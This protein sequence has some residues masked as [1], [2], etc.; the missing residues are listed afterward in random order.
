[1]A[2]VVRR[3]FALVLSASIS[4]SPADETAPSAGTPTPGTPTVQDGYVQTIAPVTKGVW[5]IAQPQAFHIQPIGN[6]VVIEHADGLVLI[7]GGGSTG[8]GR[9]IV[10]LV[11]SVSDKPVKAIALTHWHGDHVLGVSAIVQ[12][13]P[14]A[15]VIATDVTDAHLRG[16]SMKAYPKGAPDA[17]LQAAFDQRLDSVER[18]LRDALAKPGLAPRERE[19][20]AASQRLFVQYRQDTRDLVLALPTRTF[21]DS[22]RLDDATHPVELRHPGRGN[23]DGDLIAWLPRQ[24]VMVAGDLLVAPVP[25]GF[26]A[27]PADWQRTLRAMQAQTPAWWIPGHGAAMRDDGYVTRVVDLIDATRDAVA[28]Q[29]RQGASMDDAKK[30]IDLSAGRAQFAG[31]DP[32]LSRW[33]DRYWT[34]PF[35]EAAYRE[36]TGAPIEQGEG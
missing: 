1:M 11:R 33:F 16:R 14:S 34:Q 3:L 21:V 27:Y 9:R 19:G 4:L 15:E 29:V 10:D 8:A 2:R 7:D 28:A 12:A 30:R 31:D 18:S 25:F 24:R 17:T 23:T 32:W 35:I 26:N 20:F 36:A 22:L 6:V 13:W 5:L